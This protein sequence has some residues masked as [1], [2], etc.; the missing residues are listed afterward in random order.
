MT[1]LVPDP[2]GDVEGVLPCAPRHEL[3]YPMAFAMARRCFVGSSIAA[4]VWQLVPVAAGLSLVVSR[5]AG[6]SGAEST[7]LAWAFDV[8]SCV[9]WCLAS[10]ATAGL[11]CALSPGANSHAGL[12]SLGFGPNTNT[13]IGPAGK[14][15]LALWRL[16]CAGLCITGLCFSSVCFLG[17]GRVGGR[18]QITGRVI[19]TGYAYGVLLPVA[20]GFLWLGTASLCWI[21]SMQYGAVLVLDRIATTTDAIKRLQPDQPEWQTQ[22]VSPI[23]AIATEMLPNLSATFGTTLGLFA[24]GLWTVGMAFFCSFIENPTG[25]A[26]VGGVVN[27]L[28]PFG[29][30]ATIKHIS[31]SCNKMLDAINEKR[32]EELGHLDE[33][34]ALQLAHVELY[35]E[36]LNGGKGM[37]VIVAGSLFLNAQLINTIAVSHRLSCSSWLW[38]MVAQYG[39]LDCLQAQVFSL[40][41]T[42]IPI[43]LSLNQAKL[44][45]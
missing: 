7:D 37:G 43:V 22:V 33:N 38:L 39:V 24:L 1:T 23:K 19:T 44:E 27:A 20:A 16:A 35:L 9:G 10:F 30:S 18:S 6:H 31:S 8:C 32:G 21:L 3:P 41:F 14:K 12:D 11:R 15:T 29:L 5:A 28:I 4:V 25:F 2:I 45:R 36:K 13:K 34:V 17:V 40:L 26:L 42:V